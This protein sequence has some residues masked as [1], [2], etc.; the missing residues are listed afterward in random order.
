[1]GHGSLAPL[2]IA[3]PLDGGAVLSCDREIDGAGLVRFPG[4]DGGILPV[5]R[6]VLH[7]IGEDAGTVGILCE[8][9]KS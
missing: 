2:G 6:V 1:M 4:D 3:D 9:H 8:K 7:R 5:D